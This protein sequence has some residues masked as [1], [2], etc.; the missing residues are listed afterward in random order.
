MDR[1]LL[2]NKLKNSFIFEKAALGLTGKILKSKSGKNFRI[3]D[4]E[5]DDLEFPILGMNDDL[6]LYRF[7]W[8]GKSKDD[9]EEIDDFGVSLILSYSS[10]SEVSSDKLSVNWSCL[11]D[12]WTY[13]GIFSDNISKLGINMDN[14]YVYSFSDSLTDAVTAL[15]TDYSFNSK[16]DDLSEARFK[17]RSRWISRI[18]EIGDYAEI[19]GD[20]LIMGLTEIYSEDEKKILKKTISLFPDKGLLNI[21]PKPSITTLQNLTSIRI[22]NDFEL[23]LFYRVYRWNEALDLPRCTSIEI[24]PVTGNLKEPEKYTPSQKPLKS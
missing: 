12:E 9:L 13:S 15:E 19:R 3:L 17:A 10:E 16:K 5:N 21:P 4:V 23:D 11:E 2:V 1:T 7:S 20:F 6:N 14:S 8:L 24:D 22:A 18:T